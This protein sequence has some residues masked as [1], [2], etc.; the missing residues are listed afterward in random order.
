MRVILVIGDV[1]FFGSH[2]V[3]ELFAT[4]KKVIVPED[5]SGFFSRNIHPK[6]AIVQRKCPGSQTH[7]F[8]HSEKDG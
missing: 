4:G 2:L 7:G 1:G 3:Y 6:T 5:L 8:H